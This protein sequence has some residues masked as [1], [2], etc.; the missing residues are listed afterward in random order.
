MAKNTG[1]THFKG[2]G[3]KTKHGQIPV[4][5]KLQP[6]IDEIVKSLPNRSEFIREAIYSKLKEENLLPN[7]FNVQA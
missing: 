5:V 4:S 3:L 7:S 2:N 6:E 1:R